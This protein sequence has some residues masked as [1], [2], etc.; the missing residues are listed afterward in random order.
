MG[1]TNSKLKRLRGVQWS[2]GFRVLGILP[3]SSRPCR[4]LIKRPL[5]KDLV[6][7]L[8]RKKSWLEEI[9]HGFYQNPPSSI[10]WG[11]PAPILLGT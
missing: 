11:R 8:Q 10:Q 7:R 6:H 5:Q 3:D 1:L 9:D 2:L 4:G